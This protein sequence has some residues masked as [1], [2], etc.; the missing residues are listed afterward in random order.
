LRGA[1]SPVAQF[2]QPGGRLRDFGA[3]YELHSI[4]AASAPPQF[5]QKK[6]YKDAAKNFEETV[7]QDPT[8]VG[9]WLMA[10]YAALQIDD[11]EAGREDFE[12]ALTF[13]QHRKAARQALR[14]LAKM[15][16]AQDRR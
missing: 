1:C 2:F 9:A 7:R 5:Q 10:R 14:Q 11:T 15:H 13:R 4:L 16:A 12:K 6:F 8:R 3:P